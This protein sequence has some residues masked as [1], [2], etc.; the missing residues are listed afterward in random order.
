[1]GDGF[2]ALVLN[3]K[4]MMLIFARFFESRDGLLF[5]VLGCRYLHISLAG[6]P[7]F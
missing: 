4:L 5:L 6:L 2:E 1:M 3:F 7:S